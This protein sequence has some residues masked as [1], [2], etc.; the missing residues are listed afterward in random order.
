MGGK[1]KVKRAT[2]KRGKPGV[3]AT[4]LLSEELQPHHHLPEDA[5]KCELVSLSLEVTA[6]PPP[7]S[8]PPLSSPSSFF[9]CHFKRCPLWLLLN[10]QGSNIQ[11]RGIR[12]PFE[13]WPSNCHPHTPLR[14]RSSRL[15]TS[16]GGG[17]VCRALSSWQVPLLRHRP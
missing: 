10:S 12:V 1:E 11:S 14:R 5:R 9:C 8:P 16:E 13:T 7:P 4:L 2:K 3:R 15:L 6:A 17:R